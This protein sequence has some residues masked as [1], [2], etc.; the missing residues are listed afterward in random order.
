MDAYFSMAATF[1]EIN[2]NEKA[3]DCYV[4]AIE[5]DPHNNKVLSE[6]GKFLVKLDYKVKGLRY[7]AQADGVIRFT[8]FDFK[9]I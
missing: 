3:V 6:Y 1:K 4:K 8:N 7:I 5:I 2:E 9:I